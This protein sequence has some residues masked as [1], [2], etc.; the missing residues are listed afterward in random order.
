MF[1]GGRTSRLLQ[2]FS[3]KK[4]HL[5]ICPTEQCNCRC[6][7][8]YETFTN[9]KMSGAL[10]EGI[11]R[12]VE[13][14]ISD[15]RVL[16]VSWF[17]GEP[18][19]ASD[20]VVELSDFF[21][22]ICKSHNVVFHGQMTT[23]GYLLN[24]CMF[25]KLLSVGVNSYQI[26]LDGTREFHDLKRVLVNGR[27]TF[28]II[29]GNI[30]ATKNV[31]N[32]PFDITLRMHIDEDNIH[33]ISTLA[34]QLKNDFDGDGRYKFF[35]RGLSKLG[36]DRDNELN[37]LTEEKLDKTIKEVLR[38]IDKKN[39]MTVAKNYICYAS[40]PYAFVI[41][42]TGAIGKCTVALQHDFNNIGYLDES[43]DMNIDNEKY[44]QW[45]NGWSNIK[46]K[47][48]LACPAQYIDTSS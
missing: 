12:L 36:G 28:D 14:R 5:I 3:N 16:S 25:E 35:F 40:M 30:L 4:L 13:A 23:N 39:R 20:L 42:S 6:V 43:G 41:R 15:L 44:R 17:G 29:Y 24:S 45:L 47:G 9:G 7:Y 38:K 33:I 10:V 1:F 21:Y 8:C 19:L 32:I 34:D 26:T 22:Q 18:L 27:G 46:K 31:K 11:K 37:V 48:A 2:S